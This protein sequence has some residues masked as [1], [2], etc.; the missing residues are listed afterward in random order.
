MRE[1]LAQLLDAG[2]GAG[3]FPLAELFCHRKAEA[4]VGYVDDSDGYITDIFHRVAELHLL[5]CAQERLAAVWR[6]ASPSST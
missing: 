2:H 5:A 3:V 1:G 6:S 4:A